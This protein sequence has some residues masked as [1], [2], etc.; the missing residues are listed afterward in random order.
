M[1]SSSTRRTSGLALRIVRDTLGLFLEPSGA[2]GITAALRHDLG[3]ASLGTVLTGGNFSPA[4]LGE[5]APDPSRA[6]GP[7]SPAADQRAR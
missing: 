6:E 7:A 4:L 1:S 2:V 5:L 3:A